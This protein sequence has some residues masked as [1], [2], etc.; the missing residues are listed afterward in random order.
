LAPNAVEDLG[1]A[2]NLAEQG[3]GRDDKNDQY[4]NT[5]GAVLYRAGRF[6]EAVRQLSALT[7]TWEQGRKLSTGTSPGYTWFFLAMAH[8]Q[9]GQADEAKSWFDKAVE[10][11][12][13]EMQ[14]EP[15]WN[16]RLT[17]QLLRKESESLIN[18]EEV[19]PENK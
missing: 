8:H 10:R 18:G 9:L 11:A 17:L 7:S 16:R 2:V 4:L 12:E 3:A 15:V 19:S 13:K 5:L 1:Q 6:D 14:S